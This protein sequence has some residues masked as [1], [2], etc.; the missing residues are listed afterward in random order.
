VEQ[1]LAEHAGCYR[2]RELAVFA[3]DLVSALDQDGAEPDEREPAQLNELHLTKTP[4]GGRVTGELDAPTFALV[5]TAVDALSAPIPEARRSLAAR[6]ADALGELARRM[7]DT[8][9]LPSTGGQRPH[10]T[11]T[12][13]LA[14]RTARAVDL[15]VGIVYRVDVDVG[16][17]FANNLEEVCNRK[18][19]GRRRIG[20]SPDITPVGLGS[21]FVDIEDDLARAIQVG[22][23]M[24]VLTRD[25]SRQT[26]VL[27]IQNGL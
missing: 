8:G 11:V 18:S 24:N 13:P 7:L 22:I 15:A 17:A 5:A 23:T 19:G 2:P 20:E 21:R 12:I 4:T 26:A 14:P 16:L 9:E 10:V 1:Q 27:E 25:R 3:R 6:Q